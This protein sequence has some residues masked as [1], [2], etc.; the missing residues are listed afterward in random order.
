MK[1]TYDAGIVTIVQ[2]IIGMPGE[3]DNTIQETSNFLQQCM[4]Y[5]PTALRVHPG[6]M[7]S[8]NYA[9]ALPGTP[10]YEYNR[11][12]GFIGKKLDDEEQYLIRISDLDAASTKHVVNTTEQPLLKFLMWRQRLSG[13]TYAYYFKYIHGITFSFPRVACDLILRTLCLLLGKVLPEAKKVKT[14][15]DREIAKCLG[16]KYKDHTKYSNIKLSTPHRI[17]FLNATSRKLLYPLLAF[18]VAVQRG[19]LFGSFHLI[20]EH[21]VWTVRHRFCQ[22]ISLPRK[23]LRK[24]VSIGQPSSRDE[25][26]EAMIPLRLGR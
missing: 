19:G 15:L 20:A 5:Y 4:P 2:L 7:Q 16:A 10:L 12:H 21:L 11:Q 3:T 14:P 23:S 9:Q 24:I 6:I 1:W 22:P 25:G 18:A 26:S 13:E 17:L 8:I